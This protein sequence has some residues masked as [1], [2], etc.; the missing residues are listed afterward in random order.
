MYELR[1]AISFADFTHICE[2]VRACVSCRIRMRTSRASFS[3]QIWICYLIF[4]VP[5][6]QTLASF[7][8]SVLLLILPSPS[9]SS[10]S[11][12]YEWLTD[13]DGLTEWQEAKGE[14]FCS[15]LIYFVL[16][17]SRQAQCIWDERVQFPIW[18]RDF[19][20]VWLPSRT[21]FFSS[22][23]SISFFIK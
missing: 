11:S 4:V 9:I 10:S 21:N 19:A 2:C 13:W 14:I 6:S 5:V 8:F 17:D 20:R 7:R 22:H 15:F 1:K 16:M 3:V 12:S 23:F 18:R